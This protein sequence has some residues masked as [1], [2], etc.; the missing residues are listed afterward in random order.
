MKP[1]QTPSLTEPIFGL[2]PSF[3]CVG[4][5]NT[6]ELPEDFIQKH[7]RGETVR[8]P[9]CN[10]GR[11]SWD[12]CVDLLKNGFMGMQ[13]LPLGARQTVFT[14]RLYLNTET[15]INLFQV[16]LPSNAV[17]LDV[18]TTSQGGLFGAE[19]TGNSRRQ[20][21]S[22]GNLQLY[23]YKTYTLASNTETEAKVVILVTW[24]ESS[25]DDIAW[26]NLVSAY[27]YF[28]DRKFDAAIIP[29]NVAVESRLFR[30]CQTILSSSASHGRTKEFLESKA[31]YSYQLNILLPHFVKIA[32]RKPLDPR[33]VGHL[34]TLRQK[35]NEAAHEGRCDPPLTKDIA[36]ELLTAAL[37]GFHYMKSIEPLASTSDKAP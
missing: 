3:L 4:C 5:K 23:G 9:K 2:Q 18:I 1:P 31:T 35:R 15:R 7:F 32:G 20:R 27:D 24:V 28:V 13:F 17:I 19:M 16:G 33:I 34:N 12:I 25:S 21:Q 11:G 30:Y 14:T 26:L 29:A 36:A 22:G 37:F 6:C 10:A 8:C